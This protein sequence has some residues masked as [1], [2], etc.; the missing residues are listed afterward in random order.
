MPKFKIQARKEGGRSCVG[1]VLKERNVL[2]HLV[3]CV[4][5]CKVIRAWNLDENYIWLEE[6][7]QCSEDK[8][9]EFVRRVWVQNLFE[10]RDSLQKV[11]N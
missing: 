10:G 9:M 2:G 8:L 5:F 7:G 11:S 4:V 6:S 1:N 3:H